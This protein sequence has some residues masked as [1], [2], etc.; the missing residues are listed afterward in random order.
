MLS[1]FSASMIGGSLDRL[2]GLEYYKRIYELGSFTAVAEEFACSNAVISK[3]VKFLEDWVGAKLIN[4]N[5]RTISFT[6]EGEQFY[7]YCLKI[8]EN[9][10]SL[11][12]NLGHNDTVKETLSIASPVSMCLKVISPLIAEFHRLHP[13]INVKLNMSDTVLD[14]VESGVDLAIRAIAKP[15]DSSLV[16]KHITQIDRII[17]AS[18]AYLASRGT[19][20]TVAE[21]ANHDCLI[22][23]LSSDSNEWSF[24]SNDSQKT[25]ERVAVSGPIIADNSLFLIDAAKAGLGI[26][27]LPRVYIE[28]ELA[29]GILREITLNAELQPRSLYAM[30]PDRRY[31]PQRARHFLDFITEKLRD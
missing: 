29:S 16:A 13:S 24:V 27:S 7:Q 22:F 11:L 8:N 23:S 5:T 10:A 20:S 30:Y 18:D 14:L 21:L 12:D 28:E 6:T 1:Q 9:T 2:K 26:A 25:T 15:E 4:R 31:L 17:V 19:P 3:Y